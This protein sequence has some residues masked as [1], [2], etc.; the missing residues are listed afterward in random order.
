MET[1]SKSGV[2]LETGGP[3]G[4]F[5]RLVF[6]QRYCDPGLVKNPAWMGFL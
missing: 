3:T 1:G 5:K 4:V 6:W 2:D